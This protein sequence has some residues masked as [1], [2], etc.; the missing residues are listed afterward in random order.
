MSSFSDYGQP[1]AFIILQ[2]KLTAFIYSCHFVD[3]TPKIHRSK[4]RLMKREISIVV[5]QIVT[6][7]VPLENRLCKFCVSNESEEQTL[8]TMMSIL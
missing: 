4:P 2:S 8:F 6:E 1:I 5:T 7:Q 3:S